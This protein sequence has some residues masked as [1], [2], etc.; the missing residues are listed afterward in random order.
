MAVAGGT[1]F[2]QY[3]SLE[4]LEL[5]SNELNLLKDPKNNPTRER[6]LTA[7][8]HF[9]YCMKSDFATQ[10]QKRAQLLLRGIVTSFVDVIESINKKDLDQFSNT[11]A[12]EVFDEF[13]KVN[14]QIRGLGCEINT[15][16]IIW[17][18]SALCYPNEFHFC[19]SHKSR[20]MIVKFSEID[21]LVHATNATALLSILDLT[22]YDLHGNDHR[23][24]LKVNRDSGERKPVSDV[25]T[26]GLLY[27]GIELPKAKRNAKLNRLAKENRYGSC[28]LKFPAS[29]LLRNGNPE[30]KFIRLGTK[31]YWKE[32]SQ[33]ILVDSKDREGDKWR[34][35]TR[36]TFSNPSFSVHKPDDVEM[37]S[38]EW[39]LRYCEDTSCGAWTHPAFLFCE[40]QLL[41]LEWLNVEFEHHSWC[42]DGGKWNCIDCHLSNDRNGRK[43]GIVKATRVDQYNVEEVVQVEFKYRL[44]VG[45]YVTHK[46][47]AIRMFALSVPFDKREILVKMQ[48]NLSIFRKE[49]DFQE[50]INWWEKEPDY[51]YKDWTLVKWY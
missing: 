16:L 30:L 36:D 1:G 33:M 26:G 25:T 43:P 48:S 50:I 42:P 34:I 24:Q 15:P 21:K 40:D 45:G 22:G 29:G 20:S 37:E 19:K 13:V 7:S 11:E 14:N 44:N 6:L 17:R 41:E 12:D 47:I 31:K 23:F 39:N 18:R 10:D 5:L 46:A 4:S 38:F 51:Y 27:C 8:R 28:V 49:G 2:P 9:S 3:G 32:W 35:L